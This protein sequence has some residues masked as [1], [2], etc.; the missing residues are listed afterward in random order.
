MSS[1]NSAGVSV[2]LAVARDALRTELASRGH[3][4]ASDTM[5]LRSDLY[6]AGLN[7]LAK[8][9]FVFHDDAGTAADLLYQASG[10]WVA[11]MPP[12]FAVLP[13]RESGSPSLELLEQMRVVPILFDVEGAAVSFRDL[14]RLLDVVSPRSGRPEPGSRRRRH[15]CVITGA[16]GI[17]GGVQV[18]PKDAAR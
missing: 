6:I 11:G 17:V 18:S 14:D 2:D 7:D 4:A 9:L 10:A 12:R 16:L 8:A 3:T 5:G 1:D 15:A 13:A